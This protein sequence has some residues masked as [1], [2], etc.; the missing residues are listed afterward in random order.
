MKAA[1][2]VAKS[3]PEPDAGFGDGIKF[4]LFGYSSANE[5]I[6]IPERSFGSNQVVFGG[7]MFPVSAMSINCCIETG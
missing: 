1:N 5:W 4:E 6:T 2:R 3:I 7:M